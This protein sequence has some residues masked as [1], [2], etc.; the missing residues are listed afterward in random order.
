MINVQ[1]KK[2]IY[3]IYKY[4]VV[5]QNFYSY[6]NI[7]FATQSRTK[8]TKNTEV[9]NKQH[10]ILSIIAIYACLFLC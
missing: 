3:T 2:N 1:N 8:N 7:R 5:K 4:A 6:K 10:I 9:C